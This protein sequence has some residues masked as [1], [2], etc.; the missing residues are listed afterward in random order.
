LV[1][2]QPSKVLISFGAL[3]DL[4]EFEPR[5][6]ENT[7]PS[8]QVMMLFSDDNCSAANLCKFGQ[9]VLFAIGIVLELFLE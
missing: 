9:F 3:E 4:D 1:G 6:V 8:F 7:G 5:V 2:L